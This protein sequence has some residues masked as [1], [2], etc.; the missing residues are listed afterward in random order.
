LSQPVFSVI[1]PTRDRPGALAD[2]VDSVLRQGVDDFELIVVDDASASSPIVPADP[3]VRLVRL[4][5][6]RG[7]AFARNAG[8]AAAQGK[9][10]TF[11]D[12]DDRYEENRLVV[13]DVPLSLC[14][15]NDSE[16]VTLFAR[17]AQRSPQVGQVTILREHCPPF[18]PAFA[19]SEDVDWWITVTE[20]LT[21]AIVER[22][23]M[24]HRSSVASDR[25][26][27]S[28]PPEDLVR[29]VLRLLH[30]HRAYFGAHPAAA[31][32]QWNRAW[33]WSRRTGHPLA[34]VG[35]KLHALRAARRSSELDR[36]R[37]VIEREEEV[38]DRLSR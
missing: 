4:E 5:T 11:L 7:P 6:N 20:T 29:G 22:V 14:Y 34:A 38:A 1:I 15:R 16:G 23:G 27:F 24:T 2:A 30:K 19:R 13:P 31:A 12:D 10:V 37:P 36:E 8:L 18:D 17:W 9:Y 26:T 3:R 25:L 32:L 21:P 28:V 35:Y 33:H